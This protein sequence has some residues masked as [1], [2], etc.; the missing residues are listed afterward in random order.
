MDN[1]LPLQA[2]ASKAPTE[3]LGT[4]QNEAVKLICGGMRRTPIAACD[5]EANIETW[6]KD[7]RA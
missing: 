7:S 5:I 6:Q 4:V 1:A 2:I 3:A